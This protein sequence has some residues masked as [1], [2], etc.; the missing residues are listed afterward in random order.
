M[1]VLPVE[2]N[3]HNITE[4]KRYARL[5]DIP[6]KTALNIK[7]RYSLEKLSTE[8]EDGLEYA[9]HLL[10]MSDCIDALLLETRRESSVFNNNYRDNRVTPEMIEQ[11]KNY[12]MNQ[13][14]AFNSRN[15]YLAWCH[16]DK[17]PSLHYNKIKNRCF[18][19]VCGKVFNSIDTVRHLNNLG[20]LEAVRYIC[21]L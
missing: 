7:L 9:L 2:Y 12:P 1:K 15:Q 11:A 3:H 8:K 13:L 21:A 17:R 14:L 6:L 16:D 4:L 18:C 19:N 5:F 20:F 10:D